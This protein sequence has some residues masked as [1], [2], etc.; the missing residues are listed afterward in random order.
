MHCAPARTPCVD[1]AGA[2]D[3]MDLLEAGVFREYDTHII[4]GRDL[5]LL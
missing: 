2:S 1:L 5:L 3:V 4:R